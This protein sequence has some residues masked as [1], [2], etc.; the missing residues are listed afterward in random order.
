MGRPL[1]SMTRSWPER[2]AGSDAG[3][4]L[5][6]GDRSSP[7]T[8]RGN[9]QGLP[10]TGISG[11]KGQSNYQFLAGFSRLNPQQPGFFFNRKNTGNVSDPFG[12]FFA[13]SWAGAG[14]EAHSIC[15]VTSALPVHGR[16]KTRRPL[17]VYLYPFGVA[18]TR[19]AAG[20]L[21]HFECYKHMFIERKLSEYEL[22]GLCG[23][24][25][26]DA[27]FANHLSRGSS[28]NPCQKDALNLAS[29]HK[30]Q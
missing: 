17:A 3:S 8:I 21:V 11:V 26:H 7:G 23:A 25:V 14:A 10:G 19:Q 12:V 18:T 1:S 30:F 28:S 5:K 16:L 24:L 27:A 29:R 2:I 4:G 22:K 6:P 15:K 13:L 9:F 20:C